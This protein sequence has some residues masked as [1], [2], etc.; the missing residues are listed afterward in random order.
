[1]YRILSN[2]CLP[3]VGGLSDMPAIN[4]FALYAGMALLVDF[5]LQMLCFVAVLSL[6]ARRVEVR[7][8]IEFFKG[9]P[10]S[11]SYILHWKIL[12][13]SNLLAGLF[14]INMTKNSSLIVY[15]LNRLTDL[16]YSVSKEAK[17]KILRLLTQVFVLRS[18]NNYMHHLSF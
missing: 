2:L 12:F 8:L 3:L 4:A 9:N 10:I 14:S 1:M 15:H 6:D 5:I 13:L 11:L 16:N 7:I 18:L 17:R